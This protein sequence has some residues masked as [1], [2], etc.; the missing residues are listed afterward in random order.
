MERLRVAVFSDS[1]FPILNGVSVSVDALVREMR[2]RGHSVHQYSPRFPGHQDADPNTYRFRSVILPFW[3]GYPLA[4]PPYYRQLQKFRR[5]DYD[6]IHT[7]TPFILGMVGLRWA[8]SEEIPIVATYHTLYDRYS[9][10]IRFS[11]RRYMR[12]RIAKHTN[13]YFNRVDRVITPTEASL[14]WLR[15]HSVETPTDVIPTASP[16]PPILERAETRHALNIPPEARVL[17]YVGRLAE[18]KNLETLV[19]A[20]ALAFKA[21]PA[22]RLHLVGDGPHR[23]ALVS[24]VRRL[25]IGDRVRFVGF[26]PREEVDRHY[27]TADLFFFASISETQG[28]AVQEA[29]LHGLPAVAVTGGGVTEAI[30][31]GVDGYLVHNDPR[32]LASAALQVLHDDASHARMSEAASRGARSYGIPEMAERVEN[33]YRMAIAARLG[34]EQHVSLR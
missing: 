8:E 33:T 30:E 1:A 6:V 12:Y 14:R 27:A 32:E 31:D 15:R 20:A 11:P 13:F 29:M 2:N 22:L 19:D 16:R 7:H 5:R 23:E 28:L 4:I 34:K 26:V 3:P 18:E 10:Y 21:D 24:R 25:G 17:L 9:H